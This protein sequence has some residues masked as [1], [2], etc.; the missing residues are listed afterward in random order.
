MKREIVF[1]EQGPIDVRKLSEWQY[2]RHVL[3]N[4]L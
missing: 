3:G 1:Y 2:Q 4:K